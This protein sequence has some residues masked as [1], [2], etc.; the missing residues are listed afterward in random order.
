MVIIVVHKR[1]S[2]TSFTTGTNSFSVKAYG[3]CSVL[4]ECLDEL[5]HSYGKLSGSLCHKGVLGPNHQ[6][7]SGSSG[8]QAVFVQWFPVAGATTDRP[9]I[10]VPLDPGV[11]IKWAGRRKILAGFAALVAI[12]YLSY[13][14]CFYCVE[15]LLQERDSVP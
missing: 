11:T 2:A 12:M 15:H 8:R 9:L 3:K 6:V 7:I 13:L 5:P 10:P 4:K 14:Y 1:G